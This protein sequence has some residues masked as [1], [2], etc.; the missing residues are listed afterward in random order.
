MNARARQGSLALCCLL[1]ASLGGCFT[2]GFEPLEDSSNPLPQSGEGGGGMTSP[3]T[4]GTGGTGGSGGQGGSGGTG[5]VSGTGGSGGTIAGSGGSSGGDAAVPMPDG[6]PPVITQ[7]TGKEDFDECDDGKYCTREDFCLADVCMSGTARV[8]GDDCNTGSCNDTTD[9]CELVPK[10]NDTECGWGGAFQCTN[11][12]C[13]SP[14]ISC[15][16]GGDCSPSCTN[17]E[18]MI[19]CPNANACDSTCAN[20]AD[21]TI[22]CQGAGTC[23]AECTDAYCMVLC[24]DSGTCDVDCSGDTAVCAVYCTDAS[25]CEE[26]DCLD[27]ASCVLQCDEQAES[28]GFKTCWSSDEQQCED[29]SVVCNAECESGGP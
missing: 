16:D 21:C 24:Q 15:T 11:G 20:A 2:I 4:G 9:E 17:R 6:G 13:S 26:T 19:N 1:A 12:V 10:S 7:C 27:G 14:I 3:V 22:D 23:Q 29:G 18:C 8:C 5:G 28:C 25:G